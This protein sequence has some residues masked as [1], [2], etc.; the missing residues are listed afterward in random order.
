MQPHFIRNPDSSAKRDQ[1]ALNLHLIE[2]I[3]GNFINKKRSVH[4]TA[5][6]RIIL[7]TTTLMRC[8]EARSE[9]TRYVTHH[10]DQEPAEELP[11]QT[12]LESNSFRA[13][14]QSTH[15]ED[16]LTSL[17][18]QHVDGDCVWRLGLFTPA[19]EKRTRWWIERET[20]GYCVGHDDITGS[21]FTH[22]SLTMTCLG[23]PV[24][25][26]TSPWP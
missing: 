23:F 10:Q 5:G 3:I 7:F 17:R 1:S 14:F 26:H 11:T 9:Q 25:S 19:G 12:R 24:R 8:V 20:R 6:L 22:L 18:L 2:P 15:P 4:S 13:P 21:L 16:V